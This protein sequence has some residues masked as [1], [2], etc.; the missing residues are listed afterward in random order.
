MSDILELAISIQQ[1]SAPT[2][3]EAARALWVEERMRALGLADVEHDW[4]YNVFGRIPGTGAAPAL[5]ISAHTDTVFPA[6]TDLTV[7][8]DPANH[9]V[10]GPGLGDNS[11]GVAAL[12]GLAEAF[13]DRPLPCDL[14]FV[15]NT[16]EEGLGD[17]R[18]MRVAFD[19]LQQRPDKQ[20][21]GASIVI[22]G[23]GLGRIV[24]EALGSRRYRIAVQAPGGHS[25][26]SFGSASAV[27]V[28]VQLADKIS[29]LEVP[30]SPRTSF[31]IGKIAGGT[32]VNTIAETA[33]L[34]LDLRSVDTQALAKV[35]GNVEAIVHRYQTPAWKHKGVKVTLD[36][37]GD[38]PVGEIAH[39]HPLV[40]MAERALEAVGIGVE[41]ED[42]RSST[43]SNIPL[44]RGIP[45]VCVGVTGGGNAHRLDEWIAT[46]E[47]AQGM[48]HLEILVEEAAG[49]LA[50]G[51]NQQVSN[52]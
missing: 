49:W 21:I 34:E 12:L 45:S 33:S 31:N 13:V 20:G 35:I 23:M 50:S 24:H 40:Q 10:A 1:I 41:S 14:W 25:W 4:V 19:R 8:R 46:R 29:R 38:R 28:L 48:R 22:E 5:V 32:S 7:T 51:S 3:E 36:V 30:A 39:D 26:A 52:Q 9:R 11:L 37:I 16:G 2:F 27:H 42:R 17:L 6:G 47:I 43:D 18:G 15:A 44:S